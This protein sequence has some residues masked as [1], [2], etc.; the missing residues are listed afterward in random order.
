MMENVT[1]RPGK[2]PAM[3]PPYVTV[4]VTA[5]TLDC[6]PDPCAH[7]MQL[8]VAGLARPL[9]IGN[10]WTWAPPETW[11]NALA[12]QGTTTFP[13]ALPVT[14]VKTVTPPGALEP[15]PDEEPDDDPEEEEPEAAV[16]DVVAAPEGCTM[17]RVTGS[18]A[19]GVV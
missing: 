15:V 19:R 13:L 11:S 16:E 18:S 4:A 10:H 12:P 14:S 2:E 6:A 1:G 17:L 8:M 7:D 3:E 5:Y 9:A